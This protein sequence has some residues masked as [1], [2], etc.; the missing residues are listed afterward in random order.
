M[1][2]FVCQWR[3]LAVLLGCAIS[4]VESRWP[5][6]RPA[7]R[8]DASRYGCHLHATHCYH[9]AAKIDVVVAGSQKQNSAVQRSASKNSSGQ[10]PGAEMSSPI[11]SAPDIRKDV[12][13]LDR[14]SIKAGEVVETSAEYERYLHLHR[15]FAVSHGEQRRKLLRKRTSH[16]Y[17]RDHPDHIQF[18]GVCCPH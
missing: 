1:A 14:A 16:T 12:K 9:A 6:N 4:L 18:T 8:Y 17:D 15:E 3:V 13:P 10:Y 2:R 5:I 7:L 11:L